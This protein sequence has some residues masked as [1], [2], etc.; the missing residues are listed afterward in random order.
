MKR[1]AFAHCNKDSEGLTGCLDSQEK[2]IT[3]SRCQEREEIYFTLRDEGW[4]ES[5]Y[6]QGLTEVWCSPGCNKC[7]E[8]VWA[9]LFLAF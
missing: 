7:L 8:V 6:S 4:V 9:C 3:P 5:C 2:F 1:K